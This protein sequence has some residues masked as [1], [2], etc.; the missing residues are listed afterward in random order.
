MGES[1]VGMVEAKVGGGT[2]LLVAAVI[3]HDREAGRVVLLR[4]GPHA[5]FAAGLWDLPA[6]KNDPGESIAATAVRELREETGLVVDPSDLRVAHVIHAPWGVD[7]PTGF[8]TVVFS[9]D[10]WSGAP[11]NVEPD[12]HSQVCWVDQDEI[13]RDFVRST[14]RALE[15]YLQNGERLSLFDW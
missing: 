14:A 5:K 11:V 9:T 12:K 2:A 8:L 1:V 15:Q 7:A 4:R 10:R 6:G 13:P 3:V